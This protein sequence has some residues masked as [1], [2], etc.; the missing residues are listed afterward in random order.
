MKY[1][2]HVSDGTRGVVCLS[3]SIHSGMD[4]V[5]LIGM[6]LDKTLVN[7]NICF[8]FLYNFC[9]KH[10]SSLEDFSQILS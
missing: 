5:K 4:N 7:S 6:I 2:V 9:M 3:L 10:F 8:D 1:I